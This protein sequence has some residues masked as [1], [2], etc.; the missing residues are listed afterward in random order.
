MFKKVHMKLT[1][2]FTILSSLLLIALSL[3]Y[4]YVAERSLRQTAT[5]SFSGDM[6]TM[7]ANIENQKVLSYEQLTRLQSGDKYLISLYDNETPLSFCVV[8]KTEEQYQLMEE[9]RAYYF[10]NLYSRKSSNLIIGTHEE[11]TYKTSD[12]TYDVSY[13]WIPKSD[14]TLDGFVL[15]YS[16]N[17][18]IQILEQR[19]RF[20][21]IDILAVIILLSFSFC[22][23]GYILRPIKENQEKQTRFIASASHELRTFLAVIRSAL[24]AIGTDCN[25]PQAHFVKIADDETQQ[26][27]RLINDM[28]MLASSEAHSFSIEKKETELDTLLLNCFE[29]FSLMA[30]EQKKHLEIILPDAS[31]PL[32]HCDSERINQVVTI[33]LHNALRFTPEKGTITLSLLQKDH[34]FQI[35]V[36]DHGAGIPADE[37][38]HVFDSFYQGKDS[39]NKKGHFGLGLSIAREIVNA[40]HGT[41]RV[42]DTPGGGATFVIVLP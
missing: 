36:T 8:S 31:C 19:I 34:K 18:E 24:S 6:N 5:L 16:N 35:S 30:A 23:T 20:F 28:L 33:L 15:S 25:G 17:L 4:L 13:L 11:F 9:I 10:K 22:Y 21:L 26:M 27:S 2:V 7:L 1:I 3:C 41:I 39:E 32:C 14:G 37:K 38:R 42:E 12:R 40:H 29:S